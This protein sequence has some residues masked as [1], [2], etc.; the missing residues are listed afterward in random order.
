MLVRSDIQITANNYATDLWNVTIDGT[1]FSHSNWGLFN[2]NVNIMNSDTNSLNLYVK[3][4]ESIKISNCTFGNWLF[5]DSLNITI[6]HCTK[7]S[8][9]ESSDT[10]LLTLYNSSATIQNVTIQNIDIGQNSTAFIIGNNSFVEV[11]ESKFVGNKLRQGLLRVMDTSTLVLSNCNFENNNST[12][13]GACITGDHSSLY[14][15][16]TM[17]NRNSV[18]KNGGAIGIERSVLHIRYS[19]F[20]QN[21]A[22][23][24]GGAIYM[25]DESNVIILDADFTS[26]SAGQRGAAIY[27]NKSSS[28][29]TMGCQF[30]SNKAGNDN[31]GILK[32]RICQIC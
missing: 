24:F 1:S 10:A 18:L 8:S 13:R 30:Y 32:Y 4:S 3:N 28:L 27:G 5:K 7:I 23:L 16:N 25:N 21:S 26:N 15:L 17:F 6:E 31:R 2:I 29:S 19:T 12:N 22:T 14:I 11:Q 20:V 9:D